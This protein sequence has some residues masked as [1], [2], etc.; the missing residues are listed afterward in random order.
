MTIMG[1]RWS[2]RWQEGIFRL[3][4]IFYTTVRTWMSAT[5]EENA[6]QSCSLVR[7]SRD[8]SGIT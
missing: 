3:Q 4:G 2:Q 5:L 8:G 6:T 7:R 1:H